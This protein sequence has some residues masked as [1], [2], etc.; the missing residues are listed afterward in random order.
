MRKSCQGI[1]RFGFGGR[2]E[3][4]LRGGFSRTWGSQ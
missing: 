3:V 2:F 1:E 4:A